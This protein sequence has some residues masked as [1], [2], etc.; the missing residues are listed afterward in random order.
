MWGSILFVPFFDLNDNT[1]QIWLFNARRVVLQLVVS[2]S[3]DMFTWGCSKGGRG[4][5]QLP[6]PNQLCQLIGRKKKAPLPTNSSKQKQGP[7]IHPPTHR[8]CLAAWHGLFNPKKRLRGISYA[9]M[10]EQPPPPPHDL[11]NQPG[12]H[13]LSF[14]TK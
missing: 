1:T 11:L 9:R 7:H 6:P 10:P 13:S 2:V 12:G 14:C 8:D 5:G 4:A 3:V